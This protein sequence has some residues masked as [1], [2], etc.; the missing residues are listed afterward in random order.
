MSNRSANDTTDGLKLE[1]AAFDEIVAQWNRAVQCEW[2]TH[3][4]ARC[5]RTANWAVTSHTCEHLLL[6]TQHYNDHYLGPAT[7][8]FREDGA[9]QC[10]ICRRVFEGSIDE[11]FTAVRL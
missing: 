9:A 10:L 6:C 1:P 8:Y 5:K 2:D 7:T 3:N 11:L 4:G